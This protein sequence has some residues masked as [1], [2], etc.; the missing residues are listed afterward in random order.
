VEK[1]E[2]ESFYMI[3]SRLDIV[4]DKTF[5]EF[6]KLKRKKSDYKELD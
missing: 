3:V 1:I 2:V 4:P 5:K 6:I